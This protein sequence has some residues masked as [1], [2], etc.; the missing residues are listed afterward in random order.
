[1][2]DTKTILVTGAGSGIGLAASRQLS[3][4]GH[5]VV[6]IS[7]DPTRGAAA[8]DAIARIA[9]GPQ[10]VSLVAELSSQREIRRLADELHNRFASIDVLLNK[11]R[12][13]FGAARAHGRR[14]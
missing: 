2:N 6:M 14:P 11:R 7:R 10:P 5:R 1:M 13:R 9:T 4:G 12:D 8:R 3:A